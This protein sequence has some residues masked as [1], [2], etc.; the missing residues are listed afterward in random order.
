M[1]VRELWVP[2]L[3]SQNVDKQ[4]EQVYSGYFYALLNPYWSFRSEIQYENLSRN[5]N[6]MQNDIAPNTIKTL[7]VPLKINY[8]NPNGFFAN[9]SGTFIS[10]N[11]KRLNQ[12]NSAAFGLL[13][14]KNLKIEGKSNFFL[15]D[16]FVGYR[17]SSR[18]GLLSF[19]VKNL[20]NK[21]FYFRNQQFF[22]SEPLAPRYS[23]SRTFFVRLTLNF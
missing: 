21:N 4:K 3:S 2:F 19:E 15:L 22:V 18:K 14:P 5:E 13:F 6:P 20:L 10:Q 17:M 9:L 11:I 16:A 1:S 8:F 7:S 23:P 12:E